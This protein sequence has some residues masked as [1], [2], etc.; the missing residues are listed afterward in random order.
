MPQEI[1]SLLPMVLSL[2]N[3]MNMLSLAFICIC[4]YANSHRNVVQPLLEAVIEKD[5]VINV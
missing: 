4:I 3:A 2:I 5:P 1:R